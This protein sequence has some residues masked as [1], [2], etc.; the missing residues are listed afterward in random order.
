M[1]Q[2]LKDWHFTINMTGIKGEDSLKKNLTEEMVWLCFEGS[3]DDIDHSSA[4]ITLM[5]PQVICKQMDMDI[6][7]KT[8]FMDTEFLFSYVIKLSSSFLLFL[9]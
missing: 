4:I 1:W 8:L 9:N 7:P 5:Q 6:S 3:I 2:D